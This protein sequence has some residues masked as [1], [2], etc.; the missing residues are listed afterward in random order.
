MERRTIG[1][2]TGSLLAA[3]TLL[4]G[5]PVAAADGQAAANVTAAQYRLIELGKT[6]QAANLGTAL[7]Q[8]CDPISKLCG[9]F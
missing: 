1:L 4:L 8:V 2:A 9:D 7:D 5:A 3:A 6:D